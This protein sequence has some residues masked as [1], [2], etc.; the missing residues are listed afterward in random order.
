[1]EHGLRQALLG[2]Q[3]G[4][5]ACKARLD[6]LDPRRVLGRGYAMVQVGDGYAGSIK[7]LQPGMEARLI[8]RDGRA[9]ITIEQ[10]EEHKAYG[11]R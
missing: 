3:A 5:D 6:E 8:L 11:G 1:M 2:A 7:G 9:D 10:V 4:V